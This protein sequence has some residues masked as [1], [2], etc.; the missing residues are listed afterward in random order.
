MILIPNWWK[1]CGDDGDDNDG[2]DGG[3]D[4]DDDDDVDDDDEAEGG[5]LGDSQMYILKSDIAG[6]TYVNYTDTKLMVVV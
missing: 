6:T 3:N 1:W 5:K 4:D 2:D